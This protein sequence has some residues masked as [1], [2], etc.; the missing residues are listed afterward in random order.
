MNND[1][2]TI[3]NVQELLNGN[4]FLRGQTAS[5]DNT[6]SSEK[7]VLFMGQDG[8][9]HIKSRH[10]DAYAPGSLFASNTDL[11]SIASNLVTSFEPNE[12]ANG[13][14]K[15]L[16]IDT[17]SQVGFEGVGKASPQEVSGYETMQT[18]GRGGMEQVKI[19]KGERPST[20]LI[21]LITA[22]IGDL[23]DGKKLLSVITMFPG[24]LEIDGVTV[25]ANRED[26]QG[27]GLYFFVPNDVTPVN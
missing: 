27:L 5:P 4:Q 20:N 1:I 16:G 18:P 19:K 21:N 22:A 13:R 26:M 12:V 11:N 7:Y 14:V 3:Q 8:L 15:W 23:P 10:T 6:A 25:P 9:E 2:T 17:G 24:A